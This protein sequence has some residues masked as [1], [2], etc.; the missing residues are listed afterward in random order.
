M[1]FSVREDL[2]IY[3]LY[4]LK[5]KADLV[6]PSVMLPPQVFTLIRRASLMIYN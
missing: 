1:I 4:K 3:T 2:N 6:T 5:L